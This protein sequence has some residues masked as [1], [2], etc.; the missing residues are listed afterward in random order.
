MATVNYCCSQSRLF[1]IWILLCRFDEVELQLQERGVENAQRNASRVEEDT[2]TG[3][4]GGFYREEDHFFETINFRQQGELTDKYMA[5]LLQL[6]TAFLPITDSK[7]TFDRQPPA[8]LFSLFRVSLLFGMTTELMRNDSIADMTKRNQLYRAVLTF[9][10]T[11]AK[12]PGL[13]KIVIEKRVEKK[14]IPGLLALGEEKNKGALIVDKSSSGLAAS[15][16]SCGYDTYK[17]AKAFS[18]LASKSTMAKELQSEGS[19]ESLSICRRIIEFYDTIRETAPDA[20]ISG[21]SSDPWT[22]FTEAYKVTFTDDVLS[23]HNFHAEFSKLTSS[24]PGRMV[25]LGKEIASLTTSLP[26]GIF[27]KIAEARPDVMKVLIVGAEGSH[28][29]GGLFM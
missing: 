15:L 8:E 16:F 20:R 24:P 2:G 26:S 4:T 9:I 12:H 13:V 27:L 11:V 5:Q 14:R 17:Q 29:A 7:R 25:A 6:L 3:Y 23:G 21:R 22:V 19:R 10:T 28:Y 1:G 18:A